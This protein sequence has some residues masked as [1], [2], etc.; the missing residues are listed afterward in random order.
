MIGVCIPIENSPKPEGMHGSG[1]S[2]LTAIENYFRVL[3]HKEIRAA[4]KISILE[5][6]K[7][8][9]VTPFAHETDYEYIPTPG[10]YG[11]DE[12]TLLVE[13]ADMKFRVKFQFKVLELV[14]DDDDASLCPTSYWRI[15]LNFN[16]ADGIPLA[17][18][19]VR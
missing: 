6:S 3:E 7:H 15:S 19:A 1:L 10:Y 2:P 17:M 11:P 4:G 9:K 18:L 16:P 12:T 13:M 5:P 8:G 14:H